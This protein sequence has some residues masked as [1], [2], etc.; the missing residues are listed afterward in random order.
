M[1]G[2][3]FAVDDKLASPSL[4]SADPN[5]F[6]GRGAQNSASFLR[7]KVLLR[8]QRDAWQLATPAAA[9]TPA[10]VEQ[11]ALGKQLHATHAAAAWLLCRCTP[12]H[13]VCGALLCPGVATKAALMLE[14]SCGSKKTGCLEFGDVAAVRAPHNMDHLPRRRP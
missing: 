6:G 13:W 3:D 11:V 5:P 9:E 14:A 8:V 4:L 7:E 1:I 2:L 12:S 10:V